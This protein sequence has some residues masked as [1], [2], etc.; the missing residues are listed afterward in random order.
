MSESQAWVFSKRGLPWDVLS[1]TSQPVPTLP[2]PLPL[3]KD[4]PNPE[5]WIVVKVA[6]VGL[7][8]GAIFQMNLVPPF[9]RYPSC[10]P[11][12][13][14]SG[15]VVDVWHPDDESMSVQTRRFNM[16]DKIV[17]MLPAS[18]TLP[19]G[20]GA[21][22]QFVRVP[23]RYAVHKPEGVSFGDGAGCLLTGLTARQLVC[24]SGAKEG[25]RVLV[26]AASGG[27]GSLVVQMLRKV[28]GVEGY[29]VGI[30]SS[31]NVELVQSLGAD[32]V[33]DYTQYNPLSQHLTEKFSSKPFNTIID[34]LG[35]QALYVAS[36]A[37]LVPNGNYSSVG[38]KPPTF[39]VPD[40]L[41]AVLQM[42]LNDWWPVSPWLGG[43]GRKWIGT[44]MMNPTLQDRQAVADMLGQGDIRLVRDSVWAF[45]DTKEAY[46]KLAGLHARGKIL[47]KVDG[48]VGDEES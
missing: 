17:A 34:T 26:N 38:I 44:S 25:D 2:P 27:I 16:G 6:F 20:T 35:N 30:C 22:A 3:P 40:F 19:T 9:I 4:V 15:T 24:E 48:Q 7:N 42:K 46:R 11:E 28:V 10:V 45:S 47:V 14:F 29:I 41:R 23:A 33:V 5:E 21:L 32:E 36:P 31:K 18:H 39:F 12:M 37:Y 13:D 1:L 43:V 8:P